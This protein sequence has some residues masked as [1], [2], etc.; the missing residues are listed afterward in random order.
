[1]T[2]ALALVVAGAIVLPYRLRLD[3]VPA[4]VAATIW[5]CALALRALATIGTALYVVMVLPA[6]ELFSA[7]TH[8][9]LHTFVPAIAT[10]LDGHEVGDAAIV[11]PAALLVLS[12]LSV[13]VGVVR[14]TRRLRAQV[15]R[16]ALGPGPQDTVMVGGQEVLVATAGLHRPRIVVSA[17]ALIALDDEELAASLDHE[18]G[19]IERRHRFVLLTAELLRALARFVPGTRT[20][21]RELV[22]HLERDADDWAIRRRHDPCALASAICKA[23]TSASLASAAPSTALAGGGVSRRVDELVHPAAPRT[24]RAVARAVAAGMVALALLT[25][26]SLPVA[27]AAGPPP[28][29]ADRHCVT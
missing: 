15:R 5:F 6:T 29:H 7:L 28:L 20:T 24:P 2:A 23:A 19:H 16:A 17:G 27:L 13:S 9:C 21:M 11:L 3:R 18:R 14:A 4:Q 10:H 22:F 1:M 26:A 25:T 12:L 8:W